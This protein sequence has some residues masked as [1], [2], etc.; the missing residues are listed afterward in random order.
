MVYIPFTETQ[1]LVIELT[2]KDHHPEDTRKKLPI[3][4]VADWFASWVMT[5]MPELK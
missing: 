3:R 4:E 5:I 2:F 1:W